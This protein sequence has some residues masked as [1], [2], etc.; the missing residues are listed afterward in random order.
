MTEILRCPNCNA[1]IHVVSG[2]N[3]L[4]CEYCDT[5]VIINN[6]IQNFSSQ[7][8]GFPQQINGFPQ[9]M[10]RFLNQYVHTRNYAEEMKKWKKSFHRRLIIQA[11]LTAFFAIL[12]EEDFADIGAIVFLFAVVYSLVMT[13]YLI[14]NKPLSP[15]PQDNNKFLDFMKIYPLFAGTFWGGMIL[16]GIILY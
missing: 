3:I 16:M 14:K 10:N 5:E 4:K 7:T 15:L 13:F 11:M 12:M 8:N 1:Q 2:R 6:N 9:Q